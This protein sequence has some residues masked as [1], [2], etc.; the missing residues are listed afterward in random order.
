MKKRKEKNILSLTIR[1]VARINYINSIYGGT[2]QGAGDDNTGGE[3]P[4]P[5]KT[6]PVTFVWVCANGSKRYELKPKKKGSV[7]NNPND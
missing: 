4:D 7:V 5:L 3:T 2:D 6:A 1:K